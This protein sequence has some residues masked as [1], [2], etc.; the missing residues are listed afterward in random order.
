[1]SYLN[2]KRTHHPVS[3]R[4]VVNRRWN[5]LK[6]WVQVVPLP[7]RS[8]VFDYI[9]TL[10]LSLIYL[11]DRR[12]VKWN[13]LVLITRSSVCPFHENYCC[14][15]LVSITPLFPCTIQ[16]LEMFICKRMA[17]WS[18]TNFLQLYRPMLSSLPMVI[19]ENVPFE[20]KRNTKDAL[21][22]QHRDIKGKHIYC[23]DFRIPLI[24]FAAVPNQC[25]FGFGFGPFCVVIFYCV[26]LFMFWVFLINQTWILVKI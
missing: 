24:F 17:I 19:G 21:S 4:S 23:F 18:T 14:F 7:M 15:H 16:I 6:M 10:K 5:A 13:L 2:N 25:E 11:I 9:I 8:C 1:M 12:N 20:T 26:I 22:Y 3:T